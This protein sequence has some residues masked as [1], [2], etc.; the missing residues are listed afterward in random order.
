MFLRSS[1]EKSSFRLVSRIA[2]NLFQ[3]HQTALKTGMN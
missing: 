3:S 1:N 2:Q